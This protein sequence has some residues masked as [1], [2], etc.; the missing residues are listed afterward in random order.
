MIMDMLRAHPHVINLL[1]ATWSDDMLCIITPWMD[2][3]TIGH[4]L[5]RTLPGLGCR[6]KL[7]STA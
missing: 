2:N 7:A 3:G 6:N 5:N 4:F 1:G